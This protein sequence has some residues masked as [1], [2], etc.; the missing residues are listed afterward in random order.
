[1]LRAIRAGARNGLIRTV[2]RPGSE[3][4]RKRTLTDRSTTVYEWSDSKSFDLHIMFNIRVRA[5]MDAGC[6]KDGD[7]SDCHGDSFGEI[8]LFLKQTVA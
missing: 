1:M 5:P 7:L 8:A 4:L 6:G 2:K 3:K